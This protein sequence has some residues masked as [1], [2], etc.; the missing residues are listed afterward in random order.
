MTKCEVICYTMPESQMVNFSAYFIY[1]ISDTRRTTRLFLHFMVYLVKEQDNF[2]WRDEDLMM[3]SMRLFW[4]SEIFK[5][6]VI[7]QRRRHSV[8]IYIQRTIVWYIGV[9]LLYRKLV[10]STWILERKLQCKVKKT[11]SMV[12][13]QSLTYIPL[14]KKNNIIIVKSL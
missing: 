13:T 2:V 9:F 6:V 7:F 11:P 14:L 5:S 1:I 12:H 3:R 10:F 8:C 4:M